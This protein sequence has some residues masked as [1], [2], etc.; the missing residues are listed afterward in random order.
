MTDDVLLR[1]SGVTVSF[2]GAPVLADVGLEVP[3]EGFVGLVGPNGAGK[4]TL[5]NAISGLVRASAGEVVHDG[6]DVLPLPSHRRAARGIG[7]TFQQAQLLDG[8]TCLDNVLLGGFAWAPWLGWLAPRRR[9]QVREL[10][11]Q[12]LADVGLADLRHHPVAD[13]PFGV[14]RRVDLARALLMRPRLL[15]LDEPLSGLSSAERGAMAELLAGLPASGVAVLMVE[16]DVDWVRR[17]C[18]RVVVL[19]Y[20]VKLA[21]G[22]PSVLDQPAVREAYLGT[23]QED[24]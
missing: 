16:H 19:D 21:D 23:A 14:R 15:L 22:P 1:V 9:A 17:L 7:R 8:L 13:L 2:G 11:E 18:A 20:G 4:T 3:P 12:A 10:A 5:I 24:Q 6:R